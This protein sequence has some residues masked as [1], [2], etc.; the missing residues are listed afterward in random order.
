MDSAA[1][2]H[3][4]V[5]IE[6]FPRLLD[7]YARRDT[8][9][10]TIDW[11]LEQNT[12]LLLLEAHEGFGKT[13][14]LA[15]FAQRHSG[16]TV[17]LF[18]RANDQ[19]LCNPDVIRED[20]WRQCCTLVDA[21]P[22][23]TDRVDEAALRQVLIRVHRR[24][25]RSGRPVVFVVDGLH[26]F[27]EDDPVTRPTVVD[28]LSLG[29]PWFQFV[30]SVAPDH[31]AIPVPK[32]AAS[33]R[34]TLP[35]LSK[36]E[37]ET[38]L[39]GFEVSPSDTEA[40]RRVRQGIPA[41]LATIRRLL[42]QGK[43]I[44]TVLADIPEDEDNFFESEWR[45]ALNTEGPKDRLVLSLVTVDRRRRTIGDLASLVGIDPQEVRTIS[46]R[47]SFLQVN[48]QEEVVFEPPEYRRFL[49]R[50]L[51][52]DSRQAYDLLIRELSSHAL[53]DGTA[54]TL[55]PDFLVR[56]KHPEQLLEFLTPE[57]LAGMLSATSSM[58]MLRQRARSGLNAAME[59]DREADVMRLGSHES[60]IAAMEL[61][62]GSLPEVDVRL[63]LQDYDGAVA[64]AQQS[65]RL[66]DRLY[67][68]ATIASARR[69]H[70]STP[71]LDL[72]TEIRS[73]LTR[74]DAAALGQRAIEIA[75]RLVSFDAKGALALVEQSAPTASATADMDWALAR[76]SL[77][78][79]MS[80]TQ[81]SVADS[82]VG[83]EIFERI[84]NPAIRG[85]STEIAAAVRGSSVDRAIADTERFASP[86]D[87][88][89][90][91]R[92]WCRTNERAPAAERATDKALAIAI[93]TT[94]Y[95]ITADFLCDIA[96]PLV[97]TMDLDARRRLAALIDSQQ[98]HAQTRSRPL[99]VR[100]LQLL[101][102]SAESAYD[103]ERA[104]DRL[105]E[106]YLAAT[107]TAE[108]TEKLEALALLI[109]AGNSFPPHARD[110]IEGR[111]NVLADSRREFLRGF[112]A[113]L[114]AVAD[115]YSTVAP[116]LAVLVRAD[117]TLAEQCA[118]RLN[119]QRRRDATL[120]DI[121][122][123]IFDDETHIEDLSWGIE[124]IRSMQSSA[125]RDA[126][127]STLIERLGEKKGV[128]IAAPSSFQ[129]LELASG[130]RSSRAAVR[131]LAQ[132]Y[133]L[134]QQRVTADH[135]VPDPTNVLERLL[136]RWQG[137]DRPWTRL[138]AAYEVL[139]IVARHD[140]QQASQLLPRMLESSGATSFSSH[141]TASVYADSV[142]LAIGAL[143]GVLQQRLQLE[144]YIAS[145][146]A[147]IARLP[148]FGEQAVLWALTAL[149]LFR[150]RRSDDAARIVTAHVR[151]L[152]EQV[153]ITDAAYQHSV[154]VQIVP[155]LFR[156]NKTL[157]FER[158][159][160]MDEEL[161]NDAIDALVI[162]MLQGVHRGE[163]FEEQPGRGRDVDYD[164]LVDA[165]D[166]LRL[167]T[168]DA[169]IWSLTERIVDCA[170]APS[171]D[172]PLSREQR[173]DIANRLQQVAASKL[174][175]PR[176]IQHDGPR[177]VADA[178]IERLRSINAERW[179][180]IIARARQVPNTSDS[181][182]VLTLVESAMPRG[183]NLGR[184]NLRREAIARINE[185]PCAV[186]RIGRFLFFADTV[187]NQDK[188]DAERAVRSAAAAVRTATRVAGSNI[189][190]LLD[191]A[192]RIDPS[193]AQTLAKDIDDDPARAGMRRRAKD[194]VKL[195]E[196]KKS[197]GTSTR[198]DDG[199]GDDLDP[200]E[201]AR[202]A[203]MALGALNAGLRRPVGLRAIRG[204]APTAAELP[205]T[206]ALPIYEWI[207]ANVCRLPEQSSAQRG[208]VQALF[209]AVVKTADL[210]HLLA[211]SRTERDRARP[212]TMPSSNANTIFVDAHERQKVVEHLRSWFTS[213]SVSLVTICDPY[214]GPE[215]LDIVELINWCAPHATFRILTSRRYHDQQRTRRPYRQAYIQAWRSRSDQELP[216]VDVTVMGVEPYGDSPIHDRW[217]IADER[218]ISLGTSASSIGRS[219]LAQIHELSRTSAAECL[220]RLAPY[221]SREAL[222]HDG[223]RIKYEIFDLRPD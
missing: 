152:F 104:G 81:S 17:S 114:S 183:E 158:L 144:R 80:N 136:G 157:V 199:L 69:V 154:F 92:H 213:Q 195:L 109:G 217:I 171:A 90:F 135:R 139:S 180:G 127:V 12:K 97:F 119:T 116:A 51:E 126:S 160:S 71:D 200:R 45:S 149:Q 30:L 75:T 56:A 186:D 34:V 123:A 79:S 35:V 132:L 197:L 83:R 177:I 182:F 95:T 28:L 42:A 203:S 36:S 192:Y 161:R 138:D 94:G 173:T 15:Q 134:F 21:D 122:L 103:E 128:P 179:K 27:D 14:C 146:E 201:Y 191:V 11:H 168:D 167:C 62:P 208:V 164:S 6:S 220:R 193:L 96:R 115:Q 74:L 72:E 98:P 112:E 19:L 31:T 29:S 22:S 46:A 59:L 196:L 65:V 76:L 52:S 85:F 142:R 216:D 113:V 99:A 218:A 221:L 215:D 219:R 210:A 137:V 5:A 156:A 9:H 222:I 174:P 181:G 185:V 163:P 60:A 3:S 155:A 68:L 24:A 43:P 105:I 39:A 169:S 33:T 117:R 209:E 93:G 91:L 162:F 153:S 32:G 148:S 188:Q 184:V 49:E 120:R 41:K 10:D 55:L 140:T 223:A 26:E 18:L 78:W 50:K 58:A 7:W 198:H 143:G 141:R 16:R 178:H 204:S 40:V 87:K 67:L 64:V 53:S 57:R 147:L 70:G 129:L 86:E 150:H 2:S 63:A 84:E 77:A 121:V 111:H 133:V 73:L 166:L 130:I 82:E 89:Y 100:H 23:I 38:V 61:E 206:E 176:G 151:P 20:V 118:R 159:Q 175:S 187:L 66:D 108:L 37:I 125:I 207:V 170:V 165:C 25:A 102:A 4:L 88:L 212:L 172:Q 54:L 44:E 131:S 47:Y 189:T 1:T 194:R 190:R 48:E 101:L 145:L 8:V 13:V 107:E 106:V 110:T 205:L 214:F 124:L 202:A 211:T